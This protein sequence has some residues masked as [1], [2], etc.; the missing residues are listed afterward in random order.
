MK[1]V[2]YALIAAL[3]VIGIDQLVKHWAYTV[4][5]TDGPM[6]VLGDVLIFQYSENTGAA[7]GIF[8]GMTS[9]LS[10]FTAILIVGLL[11]LLFMK[12]ITHPLA[13]W[14]VSMIIAGG[15]GNLID[16]IF[17]G[18]VVDFIYFTPINFP[19]FNLADT[20][21]VVGEILLVFYILFLHDKKKPET[22]EPVEQIEVNTKE[23]CSTDE[24]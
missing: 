12:K 18:F 23:D 21:V 17:R 13:V 16:R 9:L 5:R 2:T 19:I 8:Q 15:I 11:V 10:I 20:V 1:R 3:G 14:S 22:I 4:L 24:N 6:Q 7:F